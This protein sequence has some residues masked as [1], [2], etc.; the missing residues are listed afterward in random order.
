MTSTSS[1]LSSRAI[2]G[3]YFLL[4]A[5]G[6]GLLVSIPPATRVAQLMEPH[7]EPPPQT[8]FVVYVT[9]TALLGLA[10]GSASAS[11][12]RL[13]WNTILSL[14]V[15]AMFGQF[16]A[17]PF[18]IFS[19]ALLPG[20]DVALLLLIV[21]A[22]MAAFMFSL[23][24]LRLGIWGSARRSRPFVLQYTLFGL[25]LVVPWIV[26]FLARIP[27]IVAAFSPIGAALRIMQPASG[28]ENALAFTSVLLMICIQL[29]S[30]RRPI[31]RS[32]AV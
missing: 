32:H 4:F 10:R 2:Q 14:S 19:R 21:Y 7:W 16:L 3:Y 9:I 24:G 18:L 31:R 12:G 5:C 8:F 17:L 6:I 20:R 27:S 29:F 26:S 11:W 22:T 23:I 13:R 25:F 30:I 1:V 28:A 15:H